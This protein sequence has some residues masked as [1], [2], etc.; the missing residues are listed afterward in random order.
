MAGCNMEAEATA[1]RRPRRDSLIAAP[2]GG[3]ERRQGLLKPFKTGYV[4]A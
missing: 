2:A 1:H 4:V 3:L